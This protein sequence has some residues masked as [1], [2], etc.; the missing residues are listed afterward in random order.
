MERPIVAIA[1]GDP[2]GIGPELVAKIL[3]DPVTY[4]RC[5]P[6]VVGDERVVEDACRSL[7]LE[8]RARPIAR[9][10]E[11]SWDAATIDVLRPVGLRID[12]VPT[13]EVDPAMGRAA[14]LCL[15]AVA[16]LACAGVID[17]AVL[18]PM[19]KQA[20]HLAGYDWIDELAFLA[21]LTRSPEPL[22]LGAVSP[23]LWTVAVTMHIP[24]GAVAGA[25]TRERVV[26]SIGHL[27]GA[28]RRVGF[29]APRIAVAALNPHAGEGGD[30]GREEIEV[31][32]P[33]IGDAR[34]NG[35]CVEGPVPADFVFVRA[36]RGEFD[37]VVCMYHDQANIARKLLAT[38]TGATIYLGLPVVCATTAHGTAFDIAGK[39]IADP[40]SLAAALNYTVLLSRRSSP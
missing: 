25:I 24:V 21:D 11:A 26:Q 36:R 8:L 14:A 9:V 32:A 37:G 4:A 19:H 34:Q 40:G 29:A 16:E 15:T 20:F 7:G 39:G 10:E 30:L 2:A 3:V 22:L 18:A 38:T 35:L 28:L 23:A 13:G 6:L 17:G 5:R 12:W 27:A 1:M 31:I 33:A